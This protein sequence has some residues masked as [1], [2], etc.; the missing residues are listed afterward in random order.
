MSGIEEA[1]EEERRLVKKAFERV[2]VVPR[3]VDEMSFEAIENKQFFLRMRKLRQSLVSE[4][5]IEAQS[6]NL[7]LPTEAHNTRLNL[8][9]KELKN[10]ISRFEA[11]N[12]LLGD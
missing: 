5:K 2:L 4:A 1:C 6:L 7:N 12:E 11:R 10:D 9:L 8:T 3:L